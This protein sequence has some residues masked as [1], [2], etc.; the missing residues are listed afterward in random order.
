MVQRV[1]P[2]SRI[3]N[4]GCVIPN[5]FARASCFTSRRAIHAL[6]S[7]ETSSVC[8]STSSLATRQG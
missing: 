6:T 4:E 1:R 3:D 7:P 2:R 5:A 8:C